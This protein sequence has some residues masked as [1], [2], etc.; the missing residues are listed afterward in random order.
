MDESYARTPAFLWGSDTR[1]ILL[2]PVADVISYLSG[3]CIFIPLL[4]PPMITEADIPPS[5]TNES[6]YERPTLPYGLTRDHAVSL[7]HNAISHVFNT[8]PVPLVPS[9][10]AQVK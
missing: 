3:A 7:F 6:S 9:A 4:A 2:S 5:D 10:F 8:P 1:W